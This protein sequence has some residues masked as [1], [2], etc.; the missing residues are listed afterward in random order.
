MPD[1]ETRT[2]EF[3]RDEAG[4]LFASEHVA[5]TSWDAALLEPPQ[6]AVADVRV[7]HLLGGVPPLAPELAAALPGWLAV[8]RQARRGVADLVATYQVAGRVVEGEE[9]PTAALVQR[10]WRAAPSWTPPRP[11]LQS[12]LE[13][14]LVAIHSPAPTGPAVEEPADLAVLTRFALAHRRRDEAWAVLADLDG[15]A[16][17]ERWITRTWAE[18]DELATA[19][20]IERMLDQGATEEVAWLRYL[21]EAAIVVSPAGAPDHQPELA[22]LEVDRRALLQQATPWR[23]F[24]ERDLGAAMPAVRAWVGR[25]RVAYDRYYREALARLEARRAAIEVAQSQASMLRRL[26]SIPALGRG[27]GAEAVARLEAAAA[28]VEAVPA[29]AETERPVTAGLRLGGQFSAEAAA[30]AAIEGVAAAADR[31]QRRL[32][33]ALASLVMGRTDVGPLDRVLQ[34]LLASDLDGLDS[35]LSEEV[36]QQIEALIRDDAGRHATLP[37]G[38]L[39]ELAERVPVVT[40]A[41]LEAAMTAWREVLEE[42][43]ARDSAIRLA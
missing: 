10:L 21:R 23:Y 3:H 26:A 43:L 1:H 37:E 41:N 36:A 4:T 25:Y 29:L 12:Y 15:E 16:A 35:V 34:T 28:E 14:A 22:E 24:E 18:P 17:L 19:V 2:V 7:V 8:T 40:A 39:R 32:A 13:A 5:T 11:E 6:L 38:L 20:L 30:T 42:R 27:D 31:R 33:G 9:D